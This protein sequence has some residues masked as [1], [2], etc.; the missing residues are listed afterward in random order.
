MNKVCLMGRF[1]ADPVFKTGGKMDTAT[2]TLAVN[3]YNSDADFIRCVAFGKTA[4]NIQKYCTKGMQ[5]CVTGNIKT[6]SYTRE[7]GLKVYTTD[8]LVETFDFTAKPQHGLDEKKDDPSEG[9]VDADGLAD[10]GL[11]FN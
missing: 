7:D 5:L 9:F 11:P 4:A 3:R 6:G 8:V 10:E 1:T 2:F